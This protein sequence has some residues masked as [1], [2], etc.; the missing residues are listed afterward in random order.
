MDTVLFKIQAYNK[1]AHNYGVGHE[2]DLHDTFEE[3][4]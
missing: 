3:F 2:E 4:E 1:R